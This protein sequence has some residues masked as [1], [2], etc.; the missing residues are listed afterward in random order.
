MVPHC[1]DLKD[2][3]THQKASTHKSGSNPLSVLWDAQWWKAFFDFWMKWFPIFY[4]WMKW[5][6]NFLFFIF[7]WKDFYFPTLPPNASPFSLSLLLPLAATTSQSYTASRCIADSALRYQLHARAS[8]Y[9]VSQGLSTQTVGSFL[10]V[11]FSL[12]PRAPYSA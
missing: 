12:S 6:S 2:M 5:F 10:G 3:G 8:G 4:F 7:D 1:A 9:T 11:V